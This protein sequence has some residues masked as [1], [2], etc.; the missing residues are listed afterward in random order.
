MNKFIEIENRKVGRDFPPLI[1][2]EIGINHGGSLMVAK[3]IVKAAVRAGVDVIKHQTHV[4]EDE[5]CAAAKKTIPANATQSIYEIMEQCALSEEDERALQKYVT[6]QGK[7]FISTPFSRKAANRLYDMQVPAYKIGSGECNNYPLIKHIANFNK[8]V[9]LSTGM[10][11]LASISKAVDILDTAN[12]RYA[13]MHTTSLYPTPYDKIR[14]G[15]LEQLMETFPEAVTGL[16]DHSLSNIP[17]LGA[18]ALGASILERHFTDTKD[19]EGPDIEV[20]MDEDECKMLI[21]D[22][23]IMYECRGGEKNILPEEEVT[24]D[25]AYA[26]VIVDEKQGIKK[27]ELLTRNNVWVKRPGTGQISAEHYARVINGRYRAKRNLD[28]DHQVSWDDMEKSDA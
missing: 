24:I 27:G 17:C 6:D 20:S 23:N 11:T 10:N 28:Y 14:L 9:I 22:A 3:Q 16:S 13:L 26:S 4:I 18:V 19:R 7:I 25:F 8:P 21:R 12:I 2:A 5:M 1:I 15:A